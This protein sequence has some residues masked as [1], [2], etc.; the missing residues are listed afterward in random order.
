MNV[1][2]EGRAITTQAHHILYTGDTKHF[3]KFQN[4]FRDF[5][6]S[7]NNLRRLLSLS[8][9]DRPANKFGALQ[10]ASGSNKDPQS[11][12]CSPTPW[13]SP[14][15]KTP[16]SCEAVSTFYVTLCGD[17][18][19]NPRSNKNLETQG[20]ASPEVNKGNTSGICLNLSCFLLRL[21]FRG[22]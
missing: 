13:T 21:K 10:A 15:P 22:L 6:N 12:T 2:T 17:N 4:Y 3:Q 20:P 14:K 9:S 16:L 11:W 18:S 8:V 7:C 5:Q 19:T 1:N